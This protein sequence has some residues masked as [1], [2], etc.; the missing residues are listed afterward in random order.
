MSAKAESQSS[1]MDTVKLVVAALLVGAGI[2]GFSVYS[3]MSQLYRVLALVAIV[4]LAAGIA[5]STVSGK[6]LLAFLKNSR[7]E[8]RKMV[9]PTRVETMQ[10]TLMVVVIVILLSIFLWLVDMLLGAGIG[11]LLRR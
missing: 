8:V 6:G 5:L 7:T 2:V 1:M 9:W 10:T 11:S 4:L 3:E